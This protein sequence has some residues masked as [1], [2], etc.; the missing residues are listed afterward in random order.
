MHRTAV[1]RNRI[2]NWRDLAYSISYNFLYTLH[3]DTT[4]T[5]GALLNGAP[6]QSS[7]TS[8]CQPARVP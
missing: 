7:R 6:A 5:D 3:P 8:V 1:V 2:G 4:A